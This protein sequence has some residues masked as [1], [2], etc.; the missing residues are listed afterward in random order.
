MGLQNIEERVFPHEP[1]ALFI[2]FAMND[3]I[4][5]RGTS[6]DKARKNLEAMLD[7]TLEKFPECEII[8][9]S[10]NPDV[11][12]LL[13][14]RPSGRPNLSRYYAMY[15][16]VAKKRDLQFIDLFKAWNAFLKDDLDTMKKHIPDGVHPN[17]LGTKMVI[18]PT[19]LNSVGV[20]F[21]PKDIPHYPD[22]VKKRPP[23]K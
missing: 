16:D 3:A 15:A 22:R 4:K 2:E 20:A 9:M 17:G 21:E 14:E 11:K 12:H 7:M 5:P 1:D 6:V 13:F 10:M 8:L 19:V 18:T 23:T